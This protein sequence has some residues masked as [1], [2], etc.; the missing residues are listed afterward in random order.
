MRQ[1]AGYKGYRTANSI[2][3]IGRGIDDGI[4]NNRSQEIDLYNHM[5]SMPAAI[6]RRECIP[7]VSETFFLS[8]DHVHMLQRSGEFCE[9]G[10]GEP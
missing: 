9:S 3:D 2:G 6:D 8:F 7:K 1:A 10:G 4:F 5:F